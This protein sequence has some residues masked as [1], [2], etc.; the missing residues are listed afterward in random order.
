MF[1]LF[2]PYLKPLLQYRALLFWGLFLYILAGA[3]SIALLSLSGWFISAAAFAGMTSLGASQFNYLLPGAG[4]RLFSYMRIA[5]RYG[6]RLINH[7][8]IF[9][10]IANIRLWLFRHLAQLSPEQLNF[11]DNADLLNRFISDIG[12][13]DNLF[14]RIIAPIFNFMVLLIVSVVFLCF[15]NAKLS[16]IILI[17]TLFLVLF[18]AYIVLN[19]QA[20]NYQE[21][22]NLYQIPKLDTLEREDWIALTT[23]LYLGKTYLGKVKEAEETWNALHLQIIYYGREHCSARGC[24]GTQCLICRHCFPNRKNPVATLKA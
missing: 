22:L 18:I 20:A 3:A 21:A 1:T 15:I 17:Y 14:L 2:K 23:R 13:L 4:V 11:V 16:V 24:D 5:S 10:F 6:E 7:E 12:F 19:K 8:A 9:R